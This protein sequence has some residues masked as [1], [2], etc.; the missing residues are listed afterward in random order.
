[1]LR[2]RHFVRLV[3]DFAGFA[4]INRA[5][6]ILPLMAVLALITIFIVIS[7]AAAPYTLYTV[8]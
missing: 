8:F 1:M 3:R 7:Q 5:W 6:W 4:V 2:A